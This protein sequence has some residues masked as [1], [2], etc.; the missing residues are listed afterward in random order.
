MAQGEYGS[1]GAGLFF[2]GAAR[3]AVPAAVQE[4]PT[5]EADAVVRGVI[6]SLAGAGTVGAAAP[7]SDAPDL[8]T[9]RSATD[10][11]SELDGGPGGSDATVDRLS[12]SESRRDALNAELSE[13]EARRGGRAEAQ[14]ARGN[15]VA[16]RSSRA[17]NMSRFRLKLVNHLDGACFVSACGASCRARVAG[18]LGGSE[19][20]LLAIGGASGD[21]YEVS[22]GAW[23]RLRTGRR[24]GR[25][26]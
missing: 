20:S 11:P 8:V 5:D 14:P 3:P 15:K 24:R 2:G 1:A 12:G 4:K 17:R 6:C 18:L 22:A 23:S 7:L 9:S 19:L 10:W 26:S 13:F 16:G 21:F 25:R